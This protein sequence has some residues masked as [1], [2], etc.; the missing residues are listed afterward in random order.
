MATAAK[1][2]DNIAQEATQNT[3]ETGDNLPAFGLPML[4]TISSERSEFIPQITDAAELQRDAVKLLKELDGWSLKGD[5][6]VYAQIV[7]HI[8]QLCFSATEG[9][10]V[11]QGKKQEG[12][13]VI[14]VR[15]IVLSNMTPD[16]PIPKEEAW[17]EL[18]ASFLSEVDAAS[19]ETGISYREVL[20]SPSLV[21]TLPKC[22]KAALLVCFGLAEIRV[23]NRSPRPALETEAL[24]IDTEF[25]RRKHVM[26]PAAPYNVLR[27]SI[28]SIENTKSK[29]KSEVANS[30][31]Y[32]T[33]MSADAAMLLHDHAFALSTASSSV[34]VDEN[35]GR[36]ARR[37]ATK[38]AD[39]GNT[40]TTTAQPATVKVELG[41]NTTPNDVWNAMQAMTKEMKTGAIKIPETTQ[42]QAISMVNEIIKGLDAKGLKALE[43]PVNVLLNTID[44]VYQREGLNIFVQA[45]E[46][47]NDIKEI[48]RL[49]DDERLPLIAIHKMVDKQIKL[50]ASK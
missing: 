27:P 9:M 2:R 12:D 49:G 36:L 50:A 13:D 30:E 37:K 34:V 23:F 1:E 10:G 21:S 46:R 6:S 38:G 18:K 3:P 25:N 7:K 5:T 11:K 40:A 47:L 41:E 39:S 29:K 8:A 33:Y 20:D 45:R 24:P 4:D 31:G 42:Q 28:V 22:Y 17:L 43:D 14:E 35:T 32:Y 26:A 16:G 48:F 19:E 44:K 15:G